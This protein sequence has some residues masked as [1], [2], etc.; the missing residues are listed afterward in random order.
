MARRRKFTTV[1]K[2]WIKR[3]RWSA[4]CCALAAVYLAVLPSGLP[5]RVENPLETSLMRIRQN[6]A[7][8]RG[9]TLRIE[10]RWISLKLLPSDV[11]RAVLA[12]EDSRF[13]SHFGIEFGE[14]WKVLY[15]GLRN[16][17]F[18]RGA[19]TISQQLAKNL[20][21]SES[22]NPIRKL[23]EAI[24]A[25][26]ME[27]FLS[28]RRILELYLNVIEWG[29][30]IFGI[31]AAAH[32]YFG[33]SAARLS[34]EQASQL[35]AMIPNPRTVYNMSRN[36]GRVHARARLIFKEMPAIDCPP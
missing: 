31:E 32:H 27:V 9:R 20:Y 24:I 29:E 30:G 10:K 8:E 6:E 35:A 11:I 19:S 36:P 18:P 5:Y 25:L 17:Q 23:N 4:F 33:I 16:W 21:L 2:R 34:A 13:F 28:K 12:G 14:V 22:K 26:K 15:T 3:H 1:F 7:M